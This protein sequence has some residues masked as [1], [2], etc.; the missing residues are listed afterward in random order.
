MGIVPENV[1]LFR[2]RC[3]SRDRRPNHDGISVDA[4]ELIS[5]FNSFMRR[6]LESSEGI[7]PVKLL[8]LKSKDRRNVKFLRCGEMVPLRWNPE[9]FKAVTRRCLVPQ[10]T[11]I[12]LQTEILE[13]QLP[14]RRA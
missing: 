6:K 5:T 3:S 13:D 8:E 9:T 10:E 2:Y 4:K 12:Q 1:L 7:E 11:P 14:L